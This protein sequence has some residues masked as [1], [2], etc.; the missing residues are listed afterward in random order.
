M[1]RRVVI[2][3]LLCLLALIL[4]L[5]IALGTALWIGAVLVDGRG[6]GSAAADALKS[7]WD[8]LPL[9]AFVDVSAFLLVI[10]QALVVPLATAKCPAMADRYAR[11]KTL[12]FAFARRMRHSISPY[13]AFVLVTVGLF[14][15]GVEWKSA[16]D[17]A[18]SLFG[19]ALI[20]CS[21]AATIALMFHAMFRSFAGSIDL[22]TST[23][24]G[25]RSVSLLG[26]TIGLGSAAAAIGGLFYDCLPLAIRTE[27]DSIPGFPTKAYLALMFAVIG[28]WFGLERWRSQDAKT[29]YRAD[30]AAPAL[31]LK[32]KLPYRLDAPCT[33]RRRSRP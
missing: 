20:A 22:H 8:S 19:H 27:W 4:M 9:F 29:P 11:D 12:A 17:P 15:V 5:P 30:E 33:V 1:S 14:L 18:M 25:G 26:H 10:L 6:P 32:R 31:L 16:A 21:A 7:A 28:I 24:V 2:G 3:F 13:F 23:W